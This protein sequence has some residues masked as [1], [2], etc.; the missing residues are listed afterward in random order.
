MR[1]EHLSL[2]SLAFQEERL[3]KCEIYNPGSLEKQA[4]RKNS[5]KWYYIASSTFQVSLSSKWGLKVCS[6]LYE[7]D[8]RVMAVVCPLRKENIFYC[9]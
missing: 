4:C 3:W 2:L 6:V 5:A 7:T 8:E 9:I 1:L